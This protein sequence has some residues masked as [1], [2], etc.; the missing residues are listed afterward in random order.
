MKTAIFFSKLLE[1]LARTS[2]GRF[3]GR[4][5]AA[6]K[7]QTHLQAV[8]RFQRQPWDSLWTASWEQVL[9]QIPEHKG[10]AMLSKSNFHR[11]VSEGSVCCE[12]AT[13]SKDRYI[14]RKEIPEP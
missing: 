1:H 5:Q 13:L 7:I 11:A 10:G 6:R 4:F 9:G 14:F 12:S 8:C 2:G 3:P